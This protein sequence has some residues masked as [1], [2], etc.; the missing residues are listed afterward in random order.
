MWGAPY[1]QK[2]DVFREGTY[3]VLNKHKVKQ[4]NT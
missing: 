1:F 3:S 2:L 4:K